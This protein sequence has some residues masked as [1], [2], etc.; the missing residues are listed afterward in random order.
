MAKV[1]VRRTPACRL[2]AEGQGYHSEQDIP[3]NVARDKPQA[4]HKQSLVCL[5]RQGH[6][7]ELGRRGHRSPAEPQPLPPSP[8]SSFPDPGT[9]G[10]ILGIS[11]QTGWDELGAEGL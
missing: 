8:G 9:T 6:R 1:A 2:L 11:A 3:G 5:A 4:G 10:V 7:K